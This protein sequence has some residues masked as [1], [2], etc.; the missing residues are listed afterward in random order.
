MGRCKKDA[1][2]E[3]AK[4]MLET[5]V[6]HRG[7]L[8]LPPSPAQSPVRTPLPEA[9]PAPPRARGSMSF[10]NAIGA[11]KDVCCENNLQEPEYIPISDV[12]PPHARVFTIQC[13]VATFKEEGIAT[14]KK[15]A[16]HDAA[17]KMLDR[18]NDLVVDLKPADDSVGAECKFLI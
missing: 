3:A 9:I 15:Q 6:V 13:V 4:A 11:L 10:I 18:I 8:P 7:Y 1:K 14:T 5:I 2:H 12:G 16:K 17:K